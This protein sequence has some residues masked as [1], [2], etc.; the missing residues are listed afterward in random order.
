[1][2]MYGHHN[3]AGDGRFG[4]RSYGAQRVELLFEEDIAA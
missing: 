1:M 4:P 2:G 3:G